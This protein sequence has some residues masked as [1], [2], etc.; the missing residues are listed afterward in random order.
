MTRP[1]A[2]D[3]VRLM[4]GPFSAHPRGIDRIDFGYAASLFKDWPEDFVGIVPM[5]WGMR[6]YGRKKLGFG[7]ERLDTF[8]RETMDR[9][10]DPAYARLKQFLAD[11]AH[12]GSRPRRPSRWMTRLRGTWRFLDLLTRGPW[13]FGG[14][15]LGLPAHSIY[16]NVGH[17][18]LSVPRF[19]AWLDKR[20][21][22]VSVFMIHDVIPLETPELVAPSTAASHE[23]V[24]T[25]VIRYANALIVP[26][27]ASKV[28]TLEELRR[29]GAHEI[30][31]YPV[32]LPIDDAFITPMA[33]DPGLRARPYFLICGAVEPRKNHM[34]LL[35]LWRE[36]VRKRGKDAPALIIAGPPGWSS[37]PILY[38]LEKCEALRE[39][40]HLA[41]GLSTPAL[42]SV[43]EGARALLMPSFAEGF[44][45]PPVEAL[46][47]GTPAVLSNI[48]AHREAAGEYGIFLDPTDGPAWLRQIEAMIDD[49]PVYLALRRKI[50]EFRPKTWPEYMKE[51]EDLLLGIV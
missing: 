6:W 39:H 7:L 32:T 48:A 40:V 11:P 36:L 27:E 24:M 38:Y 25:A 50:S 2:F 37:Q 35:Q 29:R 12:P 13:S 44:G 20:P 49:N 3:M 33:P 1:I 19:L 18:G 9:D 45:L 15:T 41:T 10:H 21:D 14:T 16:L 17:Y 43:M 34:L 22:I 23:A 42:R 4:L 8:W 30:P 5:M 31:I 26:S 28:A 51:V 47:A 46:T